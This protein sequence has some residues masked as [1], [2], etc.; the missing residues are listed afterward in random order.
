MP[1][2]T[3]I[4]LSVKSIWD[5]CWFYYLNEAGGISL[6]VGPIILEIF[7]DAPATR[8]LAPVSPDA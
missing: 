8:P 7:Y 5:S 3:L 1:K 4:N 2:I 6:Q